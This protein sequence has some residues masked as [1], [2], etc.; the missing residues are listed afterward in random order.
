MLL[1]P[2]LR[3]RRRL[4]EKLVKLPPG[5]RK[6]PVI[7]NLHQLICEHP[8]HRLRDLAQKHGPHVMGLQLG[9]LSYIVISSPEAAGEVLKAHDLSFATRP[10]LLVSDVVFYGAKD[11]ALAPYGAYWRQVRKI[12]VVELLSSKRVLSLRPVRESEA[13]KL[14]AAIRAA[15][16]GSAGVDIGKLLVSSTCSFTFRAAFGMSAEEEAIFTELI[17]GISEAV[18]GFR[19]SD[20]FP[21][22]KFLPALTGY[23]SR[24]VKLHLA[25]DAMLEDIINEHKARRR[26]SGNA[27]ADH[28]SQAQH[29]EDLVDILL[30]FQEDGTE[31]DFPLTTESIKAVVLDMFL[32]GTETSSTTVQWT[33]SELMRNPGVMQKAQEEARRTFACKGKVDEEDL[34]NLT[35]LDLVI[36]ESLRLH[37]VVALLVPREARETVEILGYEI[38]SGTKVIVNAW[39]I[40]RDPRYWKEAD[41]FF[42]ERFLDHPIDYK[43]NNLEFIPFGSG[44]RMCPGMSLALANVKLILANL[45]YHFDWKLSTGITHENFDMSESFGSMVGRKYSLH[46]IP[47]P[48]DARNCL[49]GWQDG[50]QLLG[51]D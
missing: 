16:A 33:M 5:P 4:V 36:R 3:P 45:L 51:K 15:A 9:E 7:G 10:R 41:K 24:L 18:G 12:C 43:G 27:A 17:S 30:N 20:L 40:G 29:S 35:Y 31:L 2:N 11:I 42:P 19:V 13:A 49:E 8:H 21:S 34:H 44:R 39:A 25:A 22:L 1:I 6:L 32:A 14:T 38:P 47:L 48:Y 23:R 50:V 28:R 26:I 46:L 37:P